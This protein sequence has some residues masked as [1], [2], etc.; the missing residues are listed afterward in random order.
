MKLATFTVA[1]NGNALT[2]EVRDGELIAFGSS[3]SVA[4]LLATGDP[5]PAGG[6]RHALSDVR[7]LAPV[8]RPGA[9]Y[10]IGLN[11]A[12]H[13]AEA[14]AEPPEQPIVFTKVRVICRGASRSGRAPRARTR[15]ARTGPG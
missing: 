14:G 10:G 11:Y 4:E 5:P 3:Q 13:A 6:E 15:S 9:I 1:G 7:L 12:D 2:G 8:P